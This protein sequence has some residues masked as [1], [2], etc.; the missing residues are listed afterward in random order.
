MKLCTTLPADLCRNASERMLAEML[1]DRSLV[2]NVHGSVLALSSSSGLLPVTL[3]PG[4]RGECYTNSIRT[5]YIDYAKEELCRLD[6]PALKS[7]APPLFAALSGLLSG[8]RSEHAVFINNWLLSTNLHPAWLAGQ[9][10]EIT[11]FLASE[12]P[13]RAL[14]LRSLNPVHHSDVIL[15]CRELGYLLIPNRKVYLIDPTSHDPR[16]HADF[17]KDLGLLH[18]AGCLIDSPEVLTHVEATRLSQLY[19]QLYHEKYSHLNP[20]FTPGWILAAHASGFLK[21]TVLRNPTDGTPVG[22]L[23]Y[24]VEGDLMTTPL[25]GYDRT[26]TKGPSLYRLLTAR[27]TLEAE[28]AGLRMHRSAG[29]DYFKG[30]RGAKG[31]I[32]YCA[33]LA[34]HLNRTRRFAWSSFQR[35]IG[36][37]EPFAFK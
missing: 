20:R 14:I 30:N 22:V 8:A 28:A 11:Q 18:S 24:I 2:S 31:C 33:V 1:R 12:F 7:V 27:L 36:A 5:T 17:R 6:A 29:A 3:S 13:D 37:L 32:E 4:K 35:A 10:G 9:M 26:I 16:Q 19:S 23:G 21:T 34:T 25:L 15:R